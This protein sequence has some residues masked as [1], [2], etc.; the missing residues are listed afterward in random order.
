MLQSTTRAVDLGDG[1]KTTLEIWGT[2][3]PLILCVHGISSSRKSWLRTAEYFS[4]A[5][6]V[7]AYDQRGHGDSSAVLGPMTLERARLD[8]EAVAA[9]L[10]EPVRAL[11]GHSWGGAVVLI[12]GR[13]ID[14]EAV[15]AIDPMIHQPPGRWHED[16]VADLA[17]VLA[18]PADQRVGAIRAMFAA[19][20]PVEIDAKV[21]AMKTMTIAPVVRLGEENAADFGRWDLRIELRRYPVPLLILLA[22]PAESV[23]SAED[24]FIIAETIGPLGKIEVFEG[25]GHSLQ[26][27]AFDRYAAAVA[28]FLGG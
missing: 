8:C 21:H 9:A 19:L 11:I 6:R 28:T 2:G 12:A 10:G 15:V 5:Y 24:A 4:K 13:T 23:V 26:R 16:F 25:E 18:T 14:T 17:P 3:G 1:E 27:T 22:D 20:P 7:A